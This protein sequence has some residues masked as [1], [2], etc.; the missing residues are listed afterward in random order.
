MKLCFRSAAALLGLLVFSGVAQ[1]RGQVTINEFMAV[2]T[3]TLVDQ[4]REYSDWIELYNAGAQPVDLAGWRLTDA[5]GNLAKWT[6]PS[7]PLAARGFVMV[8]A[9]GKD[10]AAAGQELHASFKLSSEG[11]YLAL[12]EPDGTT[13]AS[14][15][16]PA[17]PRQFSDVSYGQYQG[18]NVFFTKP[19]PRAANGPGLEGVAASV[20]FSQKRGFYQTPF[21]LELTTDTPGA[22]IRWATNGAPP[23]ATNGVIYTGPIPILGTTV[24]RAM[25]FQD[26]S[27]TS[28]VDTATFVFV[29]DVIRQSAN[30]KAPA[31]WPSSWGGNTVDYG[32]DPTVVNNATYSGTIIA[33]LQTIPSFSIV[34]ELGNLFDSR[35]GI[36]A[37]ASQQGMAWERPCSLELIYP[38]G[39]DG[40]QIDAGLRTRGGY[41]RSGG[42][43]KHAFRV[44]FRPEYGEAKLRFPMFAS[45]GGTESFSGFD[46]RTFQ[47]Y[48]WSFE[49]DSRGVF[50]RDQ[51]SRDTQIDMGLPA[52]RGDYYHLYLDGQYWGLY[53]SD[54]RPEADYAASYFGGASGD[55]DVIKVE[56][57]TYTIKATDGTMDAWT[58]LYNQAKAGLATD[59]AYEKLQGNNPDG[60][61]NPDYEVLVDVDN[62]ID[63][64]LV[65]LYGGNLDAPISN[66]LGNSSPNNWY[67]IR[68][69]YGREGFRFFCHDSEHTLLN[70]NEDR[71]GPYTAGNSSVLSSSPQWV[72]QKLWANAEFKIR[73]ADHVQRH[74]FNGGAL[75]PEAAAARLNKRK[76]EIDRAVVGESARWGNS[77][78]TPALT[79]ADWLKTVNSILTDYFPRRGTIVLQ[80]LSRQKLFPAL[81]A[82]VFSQFGG[83]IDRGFNLAITSAG[84]TVYFT[85][86]GS[87]PRVRGGAVSAGAQAYGG[88]LTLNE[89]LLVRAR[90]LQGTNWSALTEA[91]FTLIQT[92]TNL[93]ISEIMYRP[94]GESNVAA[95]NFEFI[96]LKNLEPVEIDVS[97]VHFTNGIRYVF[98]TGTRLAPG[99]FVVLANNA[100]NFAARYPGVRVDGVFN[101]NLANNGE[102][103]TLV[104][105]VGTPLFSLTYSDQ[106]PWPRT[107]DGQ[108]FSLVPVNPHANLDP[109]DPAHWRASSSVGGSPGADDVAGQISPVVINEILTRT[110]APQLDAIE[111]HNPGTAAAQIGSWYLTDNRNQPKKYRIPAAT[112]IAAG[113]YAVFDETQFHAEPVT[114]A[115]FRLDA[116]GGEVFLYAADAAG[117]LTGYSDGFSFG[118]A[119]PG[120]TFGR[121][122]NSAGE[123]QYPAQREATLGG[124]NSGPRVGP[125]VINEIHYHPAAGDAEFVE[126]KN[127]TDAT[128]PLYD[129]E[130]ATNTWRLNGLGF[131]FPTGT[132]MPPQGLALLVGGSP[133]TFRTRYQVPATV[134]IF[135]PYPGALQDNGEGLALERPDAPRPDAKGAPVVPYVVVDAVRYRDQ[136]PWPLNAAG[137]GASLERI[138]SDVYGNDPANWRAS[139]G[140][141]SPGLANDG[142]RLPTV[143]AGLDQ[144]LQAASFP[145]TVNLLGVAADDGL[146]DPPKRLATAWTQTGGPGPV[147]I[148]HPDRL[149]TTVG[150]P[151]VGSYTLRLTVDDGAL[152]ASDEVIVTAR[153]PASAATFIAAG[154]VWKYFDKGSD[155]GTA[156]RGLAFADTAWSAGKGQ[157]GYGDGD[158]ATV[159]GYGPNANSKYVTTYFRRAFEVVDAK[160]VTA[161]KVRL[162]RDDGAIVYLN[163]TEVVRD[164]M[165]EGDIDYVTYASAVVSGDDETS[166]FVDHDI[167]PALLRE[168][169]NV[170]A[171]EVH[172]A[173]AGST[174]L[175]FDLELAGQAYPANRPPSAL[176]GE[177]QVITL[178]AV[179]SLNGRFSDDGLPNP[180]G[181]VSASWSVVGGPG[182][183]VFAATNRFDT[184][185]SFTQPGSYTLRLTVNDGSQPASDD[186]TIVVKEGA[187][188]P[189][190]IASAELVGGPPPRLRIRFQAEAGQAYSV[191]YRD[192]LT[193]GD[194]QTIQDAVTPA[195]GETAEFI[196]PAPA[197]KSNRYYRLWWH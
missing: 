90:A 79:R 64:M 54:E 165:P 8:F 155:L 10:R 117:N 9:S 23:S 72:F 157:L 173:N 161:L 174:D 41:S 126:L 60:T 109:N 125:V 35:R 93:V 167:D 110:D 47:N 76:N 7:T 24:L 3:R 108:G 92:F 86:D 53:N 62:L 59:A 102:T 130:H 182:L 22:S 42:N 94:L 39:R 2:N 40:F 84:G 83:P 128:V 132:T 97:G 5:K 49:G 163:G 1:T 38:D 95:D 190:R 137:Q 129:P 33:D 34:T 107:A 74:F 14:E 96:E 112:A 183:V 192:S 101:G 158:E 124:P 18:T 184:T 99:Q 26:G 55:Y 98:P 148:A 150:L 185:A 193:T 194:W 171:V 69:R 176:A 29:A 16:A 195:A 103:L 17:Y 153:R 77:K 13:I 197:E 67:G 188:P 82:P 135:G 44:F 152:R 88:P 141:P 168:G 25:A 121:H 58:R 73:M 43:P 37:N 81:A 100:T 48:S 159:V 177:D 111:L 51:F 118:A 140:L 187:R 105:A 169:A 31:G 115:S 68:N 189:L 178:P 142:N 78:R 146:P 36:Y 80:Q 85:R 57:G 70:V 120:V 139:F 32:M 11:G 71:T 20:K 122:T 91:R 123:L 143:N 12:V 87:D 30:G 113:G 162:L 136:A 50:M 61:P 127:I 104:H 147:V 154:A 164:N 27:L 15:F 52:E 45:Q 133:A 28:R 134:A 151:G 4:D 180:P 116:L 175:S 65:I 166:N 138:R 149:D 172:Q 179:A 144:D 106:A 75:T 191:Q 170:L 196:D 19:T 160:A 66:F 145:L 156:W 89:S 131:D 181:V 21:N 56:S 46:I 114:D 186:L 63:Y 119:A 6:F